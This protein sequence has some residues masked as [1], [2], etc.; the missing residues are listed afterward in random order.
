VM[1]DR[2]KSDLKALVARGIDGYVA[3]APPT[4]S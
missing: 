2:E 3:A 4:I 1:H